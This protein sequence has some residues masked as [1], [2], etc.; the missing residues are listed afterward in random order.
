MSKESFL[1]GQKCNYSSSILGVERPRRS[2]IILVTTFIK[3]RAHIT[4]VSK[5]DI[6]SDSPSLVKDEVRGTRSERD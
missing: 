5:G 1:I 2:S 3:R 4:L 6:G